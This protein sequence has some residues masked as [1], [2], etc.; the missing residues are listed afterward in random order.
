[1]KSKLF[2]AASAV[3]IAMAVMQPVQAKTLRFAYAG[4]VLAMDPHSL[5]ESFSIAFTHHIYEPLV[6]YSEELKIEPALATS[7]E[8]VSP[9]VIRFHLRKGVKFHDGADFTA[10]DAVMSLNRVTNEKSPIRGNLPTV[11]KATKV[12]DFTMDLTLTGPTPLLFN[13]LSNS[14]ILDSGWLEKNN[15]VEPIDTNAGQENYASTHSNGT[16]P[17]MLDSRQPD[18]KTVLVVNKNWWDKPKHNLTKIVFTPI[19]SDATRVAALLSGELDMM[20]PSP[21]QDAKR[22]NAAAGAKA[23]EAP[24]LRTIYLGFNLKGDLNDSDVKGK[25]PFQDVRVRKAFYQSVNM[26]LIQKKIM[27]GKSRNAALMVAPEIPGFVEADNKRFAYDP[28]ASKKLLAEAGYP[29]GFRFAMNCPNDRYVNDEEICQAV[30]AMASK[31]GFKPKLTTESKSIHFKKAREGKT[32]MFMLGWAT[33][34]MMDAFSPISALLHTPGGKYGTWNPGGYSNARVDAL[35]ASSVSELDETKRRAQMAEALKIAKDEIAWFPLHQ[36]P[37]SWAVR[38]G[39]NIL[40][41]PDN[42]IRLWY[43]NID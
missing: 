37:L 9:T 43:T 27:R 19:Q 41:S 3:A 38:D 36:Q 5:T 21:L 29:D 6:R 35:T 15:C 26:D 8:T 4:D 28:A 22:I 16:G 24:S 17:F 11:V 34:P 14:F 13:F 30:A 33:L 32:D 40:Q 39:I 12:D 42:K 23:L 7:W 18:A 31:V 25:N 20:F 1:M 2:A 10:D